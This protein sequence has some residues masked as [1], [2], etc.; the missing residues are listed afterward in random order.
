[1]ASG[2]SAASRPDAGGRVRKQDAAAANPRLEMASLRLDEAADL[3]VA[4][5]P[6]LVLAEGS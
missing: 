3:L 5:R 2:S 1:M 4:E 6:V